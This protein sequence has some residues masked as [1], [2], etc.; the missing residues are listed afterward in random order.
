MHIF[1][2]GAMGGKRAGEEPVAIAPL[3]SPSQASHAVCVDSFLGVL[4]LIPAMKIVCLALTGKE[5]DR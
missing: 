4:C 2:G 3:R 5:T 1:S